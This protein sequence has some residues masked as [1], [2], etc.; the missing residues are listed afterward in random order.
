MKESSSE[1]LKETEEEAPETNA[2]EG[3]TTGDIST[4]IVGSGAT[5][6]ATAVAYSPNW[7]R[8]RT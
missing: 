3:A 5:A 8:S 4:F 6:A 2:S 7:H 1:A